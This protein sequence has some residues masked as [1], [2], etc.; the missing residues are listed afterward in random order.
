[1]ECAEM[2]EKGG[3]YRDVMGEAMQPV[4]PAPLNAGQLHLSRATRAVASR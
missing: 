2:G 4:G 1:M 3:D